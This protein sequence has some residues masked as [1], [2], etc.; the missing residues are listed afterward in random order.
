[1][2]DGVLYVTDVENENEDDDEDDNR[3]YD[4]FEEKE[5]AIC[6]GLDVLGG[7]DEYMFSHDSSLLGVYGIGI[8][9]TPEDIDKKKHQ[10]AKLK[11]KKHLQNKKTQQS[12]PPLVPPIIIKENYTPPD[13]VYSGTLFGSSQNAL[14]EAMMENYVYNSV[15]KSMVPS[16]D[17]VDV[18]ADMA[19]P[20]L[21]QAKKRKQKANDK[22]KK[23]GTTSTKTSS[24]TILTE[25]RD[26]LDDNDNDQHRQVMIEQSSG[27]YNNNHTVKWDKREDQDKSSNNPNPRHELKPSLRVESVVESYVNHKLQEQNHK[28]V[29]PNLPS[30]FP[31]PNIQVKV[32]DISIHWTIFGGLDWPLDEAKDTTNVNVDVN[33][34]ANV[35]KEDT[36]DRKEGP[37]AAQCDRV[38]DPCKKEQSENE[39]KEEEIG[40][41]EHHYE[42]D[43]EPNHKLNDAMHESTYPND[44]K[45]FFKLIINPFENNT[46]TYKFF[47]FFNRRV[48]KVMQFSFDH[49]Q[50]SFYRFAKK[51]TIAN[52]FVVSVETVEII[53]RIRESNFHKFLCFYRK[54]YQPY[55]HMLSFAMDNVRPEPESD[56]ERLETR[57]SIALLPLRLNV[58]QV[59]VDFLI[60]FFSGFATKKSKQNDEPSTSTSTSTSTPTSTLTPTEDKKCNDECQPDNVGDTELELSDHIMQ[61]A[62]TTQTT[63]ANTIDTANDEM[64]KNTTIAKT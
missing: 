11:S 4:G 43:F 64:N 3:K 45:P 62:P 33:V 57:V 54:H 27:W 37:N 19:N 23:D 60:Q 35:N 38:S 5:E 12:P 7:I 50:L 17:F 13:P 22:S 51:A 55:Q 44:N 32:Q 1:M 28:R 34:N 36:S 49:L 25:Y 63:V 26:P 56:P 39:E 53:D 9:D 10:S 42:M 59:A 21:Q 6:R 20:F 14:D 16:D 15:E 47:F 2:C 24:G 30:D 58:D 29:D 52:R 31:C 61:A 46:C 40:V 41:I 8:D 18:H 48:D